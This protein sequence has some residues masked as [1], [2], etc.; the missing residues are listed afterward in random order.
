MRTKKDDPDKDFHLTAS[1]LSMH[2]LSPALPGL[3]RG[4]Q[5]REPN[6]ITYRL[7]QERRRQGAG[8]EVVKWIAACVA[9]VRMSSFGLYFCSAGV[10]TAGAWPVS[11]RSVLLLTLHPRRGGR[12]AAGGR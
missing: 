7:Q 3:L 5:I 1:S 9:S 11:L 12:R 6:R 8:S 10:R 2:I 4:L